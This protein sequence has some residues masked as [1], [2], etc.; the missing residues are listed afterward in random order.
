LPK[1]AAWDAVWNSNVKFAVLINNEAS[2][3]K[4]IDYMARN[5]NKLEDPAWIVFPWENWWAN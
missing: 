5:I 1:H 3:Y 4:D 2:N